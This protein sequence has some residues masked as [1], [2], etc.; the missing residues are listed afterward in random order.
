[1][2]AALYQVQKAHCAPLPGVRTRCSPARGRIE[3]K[4][5]VERRKAEH[6]FRI[7][8]GCDEG[9]CSR[10]FRIGSNPCLASLGARAGSGRIG[11][12]ARARPPSSRNSANVC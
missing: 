8:K 4:R 11:F 6:R 12:A 7:E 10:A 9:D 5:A 3:V 2:R 1:M